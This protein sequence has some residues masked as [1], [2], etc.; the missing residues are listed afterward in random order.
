MSDL[1]PYS[2]LI[3]DGSNENGNEHENDWPKMKEQ[4]SVSISLGHE[5]DTLD[6]MVIQR[7]A[8]TLPFDYLYRTLALLSQIVVIN[9][10]NVFA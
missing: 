9:L 7:L 10:T 2:T 6:W 4:V 5:F 1:F 8:K 3:Y